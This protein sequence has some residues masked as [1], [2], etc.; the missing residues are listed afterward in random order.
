M[1]FSSISFLYYFLPAVLALY[2]LVPSRYKNIV[3]LTASLFF[4]FYGEPLYSVLIVL[5]SIS[6]Y[7]HGIWI[8]RAKKGRYARLPLISSII[9]S[10]GVLV[11]FKYADFFIVNINWLFRSKIPFLRI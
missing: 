4:Y 10:I 3:L 8:D 9:I 11:F 1:V 2:F 5:S 6:G 7:I